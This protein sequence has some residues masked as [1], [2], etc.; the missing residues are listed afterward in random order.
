ML[1][2]DQASVTQLLSLCSGACV[3]EPML[4]K[5]SHQSEKPERWNSRVALAHHNRRRT[6]IATKTQHSQYYTLGLNIYTI[7]IYK[8]WYILYVYNNELHH[9]S[10]SSLIIQHLLLGQQVRTDQLI[11]TFSGSSDDKVMH[12]PSFSLVSLSQHNVFKI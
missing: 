4:H 1:R 6:C 9:S 7:Y 3:P 12:S 2:R 10:F 5:R 8:E 11:L